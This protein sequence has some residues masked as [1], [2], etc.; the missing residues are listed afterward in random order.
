MTTTHDKMV[1]T[2]FNIRK[3]NK[4]DLDIRIEEGFNFYG[5]RGHIDAVEFDIQPK[6]KEKRIIINEFKT[7]PPDDAGE[8]LRQVK[9]YREDYPDY[10]KIK[11]D[12]TSYKIRSRLF[13][14]DPLTE[15]CKQ[16]IDKWLKIFE[17]EEI[18]VFLLNIEKKDIIPYKN[19]LTPPFVINIADIQPKMKSIH[20]FARVIHK[21]KIR[22][23]KRE[24]GRNGMLVK[25]VLKDNTKD[26][27]LVFWNENVNLVRKIA[28]GDSLLILKAYAKKGPSGE[29]EL[30]TGNRSEISINPDLSKLGL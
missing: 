11:G 8:L 24:D 3:A 6:T 29:I 10:L 22:N 13:F 7:G 25:L 5:S 4:S 17:N 14:L 28:L 2:Y 30:H 16:F 15:E 21:G 27:F 12:D 1:N 19:T 23:F 9:R 26:I 20:V 18:E